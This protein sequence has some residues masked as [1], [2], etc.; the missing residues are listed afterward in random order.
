[1]ERSQKSE[2]QRFIKSNWVLTAGCDEAFRARTGACGYSNIL[3]VD[4][5]ESSYAPVVNQ[6]TK[7]IMII[8]LNIRELGAM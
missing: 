3:A 4:Y 8:A 2:H 6:V 7:R 1:M 5:S